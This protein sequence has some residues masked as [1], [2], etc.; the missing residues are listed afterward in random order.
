MTSESWESTRAAVRLPSK[1][2]FL[3]SSS[4]LFH[5]L[6]RMAFWWKT[7]T[8]YFTQRWKSEMQ[9][10]G[11]FCY[12]VGTAQMGLD[13][14]WIFDHEFPWP[15]HLPFTCWKHVIYMLLF[16]LRPVW[17]KDC[18]WNILT[19]FLISISGKENYYTLQLMLYVHSSLQHWE[20]ER[21]KVWPQTTDRACFGGVL[22]HWEV[23]PGHRYQWVKVHKL[24]S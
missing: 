18:V 15:G 10:R 14:A 1:P 17:K 21:Q 12:R 3:R 11:T 22:Q 19:P 5:H 4:Q 8:V 9:R 2:R 13:T 23:I 24:R 6:Y 16:L 20:R 7:F